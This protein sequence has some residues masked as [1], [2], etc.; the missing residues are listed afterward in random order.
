MA[1]NLSQVK[2]VCIANT[3]KFSIL[4]ITFEE[5]T[6][7]CVNARNVQHKS[8]PDILV[9]GVYRPKTC[10]SFYCKFVSLILVK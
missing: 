9:K 7:Y 5:Y 10:F 1:T 3:N 8:Q 6:K 2:E 4:E